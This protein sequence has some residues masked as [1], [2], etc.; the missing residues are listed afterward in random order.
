MKYISLI[1]SLC[2]MAFVSCGP[3]Y[4]DS[5]WSKF[6]KSPDLKIISQTSDYAIPKGQ[7]YNTVFINDS[8]V[9]AITITAWSGAPGSYVEFIAASQVINV[10]TTAGTTIGNLGEGYGI[11]ALTGTWLKLYSTAA[12]KLRVATISG[13]R[14]ALKQGDMTP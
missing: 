14:L 6:T 5:G 4:A 10:T 7:A 8:N 1:I 13:T 3:V 2:M 9:Q 12:N 11:Q